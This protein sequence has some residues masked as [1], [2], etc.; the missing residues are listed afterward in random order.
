MSLDIEM[1]NR[2]SLSSTTAYEIRRGWTGPY[3]EAVTQVGT[4]G[5]ESSEDWIIYP[6]RLDLLT[7]YVGWVPDP[8]L[9]TTEAVWHTG[10]VLYNLPYNVLNWMYTQR[11]L[12]DDK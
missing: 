10:V 4:E 9:G 6:N 7:D 1:S 12:V 8:G 2:F 5:L 3:G 11:R